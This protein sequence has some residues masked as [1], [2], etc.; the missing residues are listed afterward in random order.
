MLGMRLTTNIDGMLTGGIIVETEAYLGTIDKACHSYNGVV[1]KRNEV[2]Y[3]EAGI[4]Y[5]YLCYGMHYLLNFVTG[6][7]NHPHAV[8]VRAIEPQT[9]INFMLA[10]RKQTKLTP[11]LTNGPGKLTQALGIHAMHNRMK[12]GTMIQ[13]KNRLNI[14]ENQI[15]SSP[16][17][18]VNYAEEW[19]NRPL[20]FRLKNN[21]YAGK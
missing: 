9:G 1:T 5:I 17:V 8:L 4:I 13:L 19:A 15:V 7:K 14:P 10:R 21:Q 11:N 20:R 3:Q 6:P 16:R 18:G 2:M 12:T